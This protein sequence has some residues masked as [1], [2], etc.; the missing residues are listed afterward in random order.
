MEFVSSPFFILSISRARPDRSFDLPSRMYIISV[1]ML[2][3]Y[4]RYHRGSSSSFVSLADNSNDNSSIVSR[5]DRN[6][7]ARSSFIGLGTSPTMSTFRLSPPNV[8][9]VDSEEVRIAAQNLRRPSYLNGRMYSDQSRMSKAK[10][11]ASETF[12][13]WLHYM[14]KPEEVNSGSSFGDSKRMPAAEDRDRL[15]EKESSAG[16]GDV[17]PSRWRG[18]IEEEPPSA[19]LT[20]AGMMGGGTGWVKNRDVE[21][22]AGAGTISFDTDQREE[23]LRSAN[24]II[25]YSL[26]PLGRTASPFLVP[27]EPPRAVLSPPQRPER[28]SSLLPYETNAQ[29]Q[30]VTPGSPA[31]SFNSAVGIVYDHPSPDVDTSSNNLGTTSSRASPENDK[32]RRPISSFN[33]QSSRS[34]AQSSSNSDFSIG[35]YVSDFPVPPRARTSYQRQEVGVAIGGEDIVETAE[36]VDDEFDLLPPPMMPAAKA[37]RISTSSATSSLGV[38]A[39]GSESRNAMNAEFDV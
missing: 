36:E 4:H 24:P 30:P 28:P 37:E 38:R 25:N 20:S 32:S 10:S 33:R 15:W 12:T 19:A 8:S 22:G 35:N 21:S 18:V 29:R 5:S 31:R 17:G 3:V 11:R 14:R 1:F 13:N 27:S 7:K 9:S 34:T 23:D 39:S 26:P 6:R 2:V 16:Y